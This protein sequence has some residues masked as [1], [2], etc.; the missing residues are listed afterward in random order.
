MY[1]RQEYEKG[2]VFIDRLMAQWFLTDYLHLKGQ[3]AITKEFTKKE[4]FIDP[5]S[6]NTTAKAQKEPEL[7]GDLY[8]TK[9][10]S[11]NWD[12]QIGAYVSKSFGAHALN[13]SLIHICNQE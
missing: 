12:A 1:K 6:S 2:D 9:G 7:E 11:T 5:L 8:L 13:L 4:R 3:I 10:E